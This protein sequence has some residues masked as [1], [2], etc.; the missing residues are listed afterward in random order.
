MK[1]NVLRDKSKNINGNF[2]IKTKDSTFF[3]NGKCS[4]VIINQ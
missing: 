4:Q 1:L 3:I 2:T